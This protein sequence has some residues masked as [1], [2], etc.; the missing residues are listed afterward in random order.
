MTADATRYDALAHEVAAA[1]SSYC[2]A[3]SWTSDVAACAATEVAHEHAL[4]PH[5]QE[6]AG[7][8]SHLD[9]AEHQTGHADH[10]DCACTVTN[11][12]AE[13]ERH[14][15]AACSGSTAERDAEAARHCAAMMGSAA[16]MHERAGEL[17]Q[18]PDE[19]RWG[20]GDVSAPSCAGGMHHGM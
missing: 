14:R 16:R 9:D 7:M 17:T 15:S 11:M 19:W 1:T 12:Q 6:M 4:V 8:A 20:T 2:D 10:M 5:L 3:H 13:I 18:H